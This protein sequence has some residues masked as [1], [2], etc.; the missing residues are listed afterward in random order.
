[1]KTTNDY[2]KYGK[3]AI[4]LGDY[5]ECAVFGVVWGLVVYIVAFWV[6]YPLLTR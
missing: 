1:M 4:I 2:K 6:F 5:V 3:E